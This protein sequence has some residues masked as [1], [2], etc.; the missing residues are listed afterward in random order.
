MIWVWWATVEWY[1]QGKTEK[2]GEKTVPMLLCPP[3]IQHGLTRARTRASAA[4]GRRLTTWAMARP[5]LWL[6][7][8]YQTFNWNV[9]CRWLGRLLDFATHLILYPVGNNWF[10]RPPSVLTPAKHMRCLYCDVTLLVCRS[11]EPLSQGSL[12]MPHA[13]QYL[14][15]W[16]LKSFQRCNRQTRE[17]ILSIFK[18]WHHM[19]QFF[20]KTIICLMNWLNI[21]TDNTQID[22]SDSIIA[23]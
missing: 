20:C 14:Y 21:P 13:W 19:I 12:V 17:W 8:L 11:L 15:S 4:R 23:R 1:W 3:Q 9:H 18:E 10:C 22:K 16:V 2:L 5:V 7:P 6:T